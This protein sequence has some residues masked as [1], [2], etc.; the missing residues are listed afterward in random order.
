MSSKRNTD[1]RGDEFDDL[2]VLSQRLLGYTP[3][4]SINR[5]VPPP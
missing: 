3:L 2:D 4:T 1:A 5:I